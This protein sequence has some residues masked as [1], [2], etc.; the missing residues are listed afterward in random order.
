[1]TTIYWLRI[2]TVLLGLSSISL[3]ARGDAALDDVEALIEQ[4]RTSAALTQVRG[5]LERHPDDPR[6]LFLLARAH[7]LSGQRAQAIE[8]YQRLNK[9]YPSLPEPYMN[10]AAVYAD[11]GQYERARA[12][13][14]EALRAHST[15]GKIYENLLSL[16]AT[17][18][19]RAYQNALSLNGETVTPR[20][21]VSVALDSWSPA[22][23][24][25]VL[26]SAQAPATSL[27][28]V[29]P[30]PA[31]SPPV[32]RVV[33]PDVQP[34]K[35]KVEVTATTVAVATSPPES[36]L[37]PVD[38]ERSRLLAVV[39]GWARAWSDQDVKTYL[40]FYS[41]DFRPN[42]NMSRSQWEQ[43]RRLRI[44]K[45]K[46]IRVNLNKFNTSL[47]GRTAK[48]SFQQ[49]YRSD[50]FRDVVRKTLT[51]ERQSEGWKIIN[52]TIAGNS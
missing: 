25:A 22:P 43:Q 35:P 7:Q 44:T 26:A 27:A 13:L 15:Y 38:D 2:A 36:P 14:I 47:N 30:P 24:P 31:Q 6:A 9:H 19:S 50:S 10:L 48:V 29:E 37:D 28:A 12:V 18:A 33:E 49:S 11:G 21:E 3:T 51:L 1:M 34:R 45:K 5:H 52:E 32:E 39:K 41:A 46:R 4:G 16:H 17:M 20:L 40:S 23:P 42:P 8:V